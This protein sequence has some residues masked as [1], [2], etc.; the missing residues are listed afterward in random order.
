MFT[1]LPPVVK[2]LLII[3][4][5][6]LVV[7]QVS[8]GFGLDL[9]SLFG[10]HHW[11]SDLFM[12]HQFITYMFMHGGLM[13][14]FFNM[15]ALYMFGRVL[16]QVWGPK[17]FLIY[18]MFTGIGAGILQMIVV[19]FELS[20]LES[21]VASIA[22]S[23]SPDAFANFIDDYVPDHF[24]APFHQRLAGWISNPE[25]S[26]FKAAALNIANELLD[27]KRNVGTVGASGSVF[28]ILLAF[29]ML[30][31]NTEL[32][33]L[34]PPIPIKAKYFVVGYGLIELYMGFTANPSD[35]VAHFAHLGGM[36]FGYFL[37]KYWKTNT[38]TF[39]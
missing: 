23:A 6:M 3:N 38:N 19:T 36:L 33:L 1:N 11:S 24:R 32:L 35:N 4:V 15:F 10:L 28:G 9:H 12:P 27:L 20:G 25:S 17:R 39:Y 14:L 16:E 7:A 34:F 29:G 26:Q 5:L 2:N 8:E 22:D 37:I 31:P 18:Y 30:F 13:H 21:A